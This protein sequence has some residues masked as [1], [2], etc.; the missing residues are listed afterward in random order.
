MFVI[1]APNSVAF[2]IFNIPIYKYGIVMALAIFV[3]MVLAN[4]FYNI[5]NSEEKEEFFG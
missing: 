3:A 2:S 5:S 4:Y 1:P